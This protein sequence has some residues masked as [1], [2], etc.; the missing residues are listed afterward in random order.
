MFRHDHPQYRAWHMTGVGFENLKA[1]VCPRPKIGPDEVLLHQRV[2]TICYSSIKVLFSGSRHPRL[3][4]RNLKEEPVILGDEC[5][6]EIVEVGRNLRRKYKAGDRVA[7]SPDLDIDAFGYGVPGGAQQLNVIRGK[8]LDFLLKVPPGAVRRHGMFAMPLSEPLACVERALSLEYRDR[9]KADGRMLVWADAKAQAFSI[10]DAKIPRQVTLIEEGGRCEAVRQ[11]L[12]RRGCSIRALAGRPPAAREPGAYKFD[13]ILVLGSRAEFVRKAVEWAQTHL[14]K[15][16]VVAILGDPPAGCKVA[17][18]LG[19]AHYERTL[20][21]GSERGD[22]RHAYTR[23]RRFGLPRGGKVLLFGSGGPMG[24]FFLMRCAAEKR[25][26]PG[27]ILAAEIKRDRVR[28]L[29]RIARRLGAPSLRRGRGLDTR[30]KVRVLDVS[31]EPARVK[32]GVRGVDTLVVLCADL[33]AL[34]RWLAGLAENA[35]VNAFAGLSGKAIMVE[36]RDIVRRG[37]RVIGHSG[38]T[39]EFQRKTLRAIARGEVDVA[40]VVAAVGGFDAVHDA[41]RAAH[42][43]RFPGKTVIYTDVDHPLVPIRGEWSA[44]RERRFLAKQGL[45]SKA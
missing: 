35:V 38:S 9:P 10:G 17:V 32:P 41:L 43:G 19:L 18:D 33:E 28:N 45:R 15:S 16:G 40:P 29:R 39:L 6:G 25:A 20:I 22:V 23:N 14:A 12:K 7:V 26:A 31:R 37:V 8:M 36:A 27:E 34:E 4:G 44:A 24:Q 5:Y 2:V 21:V 1:T 30:A 3:A 42:E 13:D 11:E